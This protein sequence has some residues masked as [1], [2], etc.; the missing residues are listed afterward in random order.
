MDF[1]WDISRSSSSAASWSKAVG[2]A[3][4]VVSTQSVSV[5]YIIRDVNG[6]QLGTGSL[7]LPANGHTSFMLASQMPATAGIAGTVEFDTSAG[8]DIAVLGIRSPP[9]LTFTT[10]PALAN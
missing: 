7:V 10:L 9:A 5:P 6:N 4:S 8:A 1:T 3:L 2:V